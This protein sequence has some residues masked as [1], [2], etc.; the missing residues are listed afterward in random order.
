[1]SDARPMT[2]EQVA[3]LWG[4]SA[5]HVRNLIHRRELRAFRLGPR[6]LRIP[7]DALAEFEKCQTIES[8]GSKGGLSSLGGST[9]NDDV[10]V[11][12]HHPDRTRKEKPLT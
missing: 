3:D 1:M 12:K 6:L 10:I 11:L 8:D 7:P 4:C 2:P 9:A 5:N